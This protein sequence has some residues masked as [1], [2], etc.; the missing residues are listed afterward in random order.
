MTNFILGIVVFLFLAL[1]F[2]L[3]T[4]GVVRGL[5]GKQLRISRRAFLYS[6]LIPVSVGLAFLAF[7]TFYD[8]HETTGFCGEICHSMEPLLETYENP[9][10]N[11]M[12]AT[13]ADEGVTCT[14]CHV[15]P[16]W[17]GQIDS[18][19][20]VPHEVWSETFN[21]YDP[22]D[23]GGEVEDENCEKCHDG[24]HAVVPGNVTTVSRTKTNPHDGDQDCVEC[25][26]AHEPGLGISMEQC[27]ICHGDAIPDF[28]AAISRHGE[29][30]GSDC[31]DCHDRP[32][33]G[34]EAR[35][36]FSEVGDIL[37]DAFCADC[38]VDEER[39][40]VES[41]T[42]GSI[43]L[44]GGCLDCH[45]DHNASTAPHVATGDYSDCT[46][47]HLDMEGPGGVHDRRKVKYLGA[48]GV[49]DE[50]CLECHITVVEVYEATSTPASKA[51]YGACVD[52]HSD[53]TVKTSPHIVTGSY[54]DCG[55]C[56][57]GLDQPGGV[58]NRT[59]VSY[60]D[61]PGVRDSLCQGC[62]DDVFGRLA[63]NENHDNVDCVN[64]HGEHGLHVEFDECSPCHKAAD[65]PKSH[66]PASDCTRS[67]CHGELW[68]HE[69]G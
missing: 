42:P 67:R 17:G 36:P 16:G 51:M 49:N 35:V 27:G 24:E 47:C 53:H 11:A 68:Y 25:H 45:D 55:N 29:R 31:L 5:Q 43:E 3:L 62:H 2:G 41:G 10:N 34:D 44:Y 40:Y 66:E 61:A 12:M 7:G 21:T 9:G 57:M 22:E 56:H 30:A 1:L 64:C 18:F 69:G 54:S 52:C 58:H 14:G 28:D 13:H 37:S 38:H 33:M 39:V 65:I 19:L 15:G 60:L 4:L 59:L 23:L 20:V 63:L 8:Y 46:H 48:P 6:L 50:L 32:H 26:I